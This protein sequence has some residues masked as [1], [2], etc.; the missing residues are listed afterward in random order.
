MSVGRLALFVV[1]VSMRMRV[2]MLGFYSCL[3]TA[4][5]QR[6]SDGVCENA[7]KQDGCWT[8]SRHSPQSKSRRA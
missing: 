2:G 8:E 4:Y 3:R 7:H 5:R 6:A 1:R